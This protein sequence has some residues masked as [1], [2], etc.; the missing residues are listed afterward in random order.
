MCKKL[1]AYPDCQCPGFNGE[2][3]SSDDTRACYVKYC[4]AGAD[5]CPN[6]AFVNCVGEN[7]KFL[8]WDAVK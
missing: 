3:A 4:K 6:D 7:T 2:P 1:G 8:Q 5:E